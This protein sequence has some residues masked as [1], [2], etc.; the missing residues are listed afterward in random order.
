ML[1]IG[2]DKN[3]ESADKPAIRKCLDIKKLGG[4][5]GFSSFGQQGLAALEPEWGPC[6]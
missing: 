2:C 6:V 3:F 1:G 4:S 5:V